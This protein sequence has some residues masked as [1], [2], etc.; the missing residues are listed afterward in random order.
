MRSVYR[1][2]VVVTHYA[3]L[4][5]YVVPDFVHVLSSG[6]I[7]KSGGRELADDLERTG[8]AGV[9]DGGAA[10]PAVP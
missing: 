8:Y 3:R 10:P 4:L 7:V 5:Q 6:R 2:M 9:E 1:A